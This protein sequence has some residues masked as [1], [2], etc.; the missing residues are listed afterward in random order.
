MSDAFIGEIR[1]FANR[2]IPAGWLPCDGTIYPA[3]AYQALYAVI[4]NA[5]GGDAAQQNFATPNLINP[6]P[7]M[8]GLAVCGT[9]TASGTSVAWTLGQVAG[10]AAVGLTH[11]QMPA[12]THQMVRAGAGWTAAMKLNSPDNGTQVGGLYVNPTETAQ[13][14]TTHAPNTALAGQTI[15]AAGGT[16]AGA[17]APH[18]NRQPF[19]TFQFAICWDGIYP[20][21]S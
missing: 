4:G 20:V 19:L 11:S 10:E 16:T 1:I 18:E 7:A 5:Y 13:C 3:S 15:G 14:L 12:H 9:G 17:A 2:Y 21:P 8:N 6:Q